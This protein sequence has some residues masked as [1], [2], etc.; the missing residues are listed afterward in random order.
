M[1][2]GLIDYVTV[3]LHSWNSNLQMDCFFHFFLLFF[4]HKKKSFGIKTAHKGLFWLIMLEAIYLEISL[5]A[6]FWLLLLCCKRLKSFA[7][8]FWTSLNTYSSLTCIFKKWYQIHSKEWKFQI[9]CLGRLHGL[10]LI[11][12]LQLN[13]LVGSF[14]IQLWKLQMIY[15]W[16]HYQI[17]LKLYLFLGTDFSRPGFFCL[18]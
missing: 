15:L 8:S 13:F 6:E 4:P 7:K 17:L 18:A 9:F 14:A 10:C 5:T 11:R 16:D 12:C 2:L 1:G 3:L